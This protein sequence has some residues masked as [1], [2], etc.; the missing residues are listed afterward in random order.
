MVVH[1]LLTDL[2]HPRLSRL[3]ALSTFMRHLN[4]PGR[5]QIDPDAQVSQTNRHGVHKPNEPRLAGCIAFLVGVA[6]VSAKRA[7]M[8]DARAHAVQI[9]CTGRVAR[10]VDFHVG[11]AGLAHGEGG[12]EVRFHV[13]NPLVIRVLVL[14]GLAIFP[15]GRGDAAVVDKHV[16]VVVEEFSG[17]VDGGP[18]GVHVTQVA[19]R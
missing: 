17:R 8:D 13:G 12:G 6:L 14:H 10:G 9:L 5:Y 15:V 7:D 16:D 4:T 19:Y 1:I 18:D 11:D 2:I 3:V